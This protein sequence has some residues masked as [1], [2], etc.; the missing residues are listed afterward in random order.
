MNRDISMDNDSVEVVRQEF[1]CSQEAPMFT[2]HKGR[3]YINS[4][5]LNKFPLHDYIQILID[6]EKKI[7]ILRPVTENIKDSFQWCTG[8]K[9]RRPRHMRCVPLYVMV[10]QMMGWEA[11]AR[12]RITGCIQH[13][14]E[15]DLLCFDLREAVCFRPTGETD[16]NGNPVI[17]KSFPEEWELHYGTPRENY[18]EQLVQ[19]Y[20]SNGVFTVQLSVNEAV[21]EKMEKI[22]AAGNE[23]SEGDR[24]TGNVLSE[25]KTEE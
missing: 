18:S 12:Y 11:D 1:C 16:S 20:D 5:G 19:T 21:R 9:K 8:G 24:D 25:E 3:A 2:F 23:V 6:R 17:R 15:G 10:Y 7:L 22:R 13:G 14:K 4:F